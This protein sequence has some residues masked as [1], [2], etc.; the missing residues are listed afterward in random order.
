MAE[1]LFFKVEELQCKQDLEK[2]KLFAATLD[3]DREQMKISKDISDLKYIII[4]VL[5]EK[6]DEEEITDEGKCDVFKHI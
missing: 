5:E 2:L 3:I 4:K 6:L 1:E